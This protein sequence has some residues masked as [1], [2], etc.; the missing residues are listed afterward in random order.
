[1]GGLPRDLMHVCGITSS[2]A[3]QTQNLGSSTRRCSSSWNGTDDAMSEALEPTGGKRKRSE[4]GFVESLGREILVQAR[5]LDN[6]SGTKFGVS[7]LIRG[8]SVMAY[9][10]SKVQKSAGDAVYVV[11]SC[12]G[13]TT[14][15]QVTATFGDL[16]NAI[17]CFMTMVE[18]TTRN[19]DTIYA[20]SVW[21]AR[22]P[23]MTISLNTDAFSDVTKS[24]PERQALLKKRRAEQIG[25]LIR[26]LDDSVAIAAEK[27]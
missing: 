2:K 9:W 8:A 22:P 26:L 14:M 23:V 12:V 19:A 17:E 6:A 16:S 10:I 7:R 1:M 15:A 5:E 21:E 3:A 27:K 18:G 20:F 13:S 11:G 25:M 4:G 24:L